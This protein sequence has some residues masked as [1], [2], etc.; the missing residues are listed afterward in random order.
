MTQSVRSSAAPV[1]VLFAL[2]AGLPAAAQSLK[3]YTV[4]N[5]NDFIKN[6]G[7]KRIIALKKGDYKL[8]AGST[9][10]ND[11]VSWLDAE[12]GS[13]K[14]LSI[15]NVEGLQII[16]ETGTRFV[17]ESES[18]YMLGFYNGSQISLSNVTLERRLK[19]ESAYVGAGMIYAEGVSGFK[20]DKLVFKGPTGYSLEF[21]DCEEIELKRLEITKG[22]SG[23]LVLGQCYD[24]SLADSKVS[25]TE[26]YPLVYLDGSDFVTFKNVTFEGNIGG[27]FV[28]IYA[29]EG[30][31]EEVAF[32]GCTFKDN[33][34]EWFSG[35]QVLPTTSG[36]AF[37]GSSFDEDWPELS[38]APEEAYYDE[39][40]AYFYHFDSGLGFYYPEYW[41]LEE[42]EDGGRALIS[43]ADEDVLVLF[44]KVYDIPAKVDPARQSKRVFLEAQNALVRYLSDELGLALELSATGEAYTNDWGLLVADY[45]GE[46]DGYLIRVRFVAEGGAVYALFVAAGSADYFEDGGDGLFI[47]DSLEIGG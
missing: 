9:V 27:N 39:G 4:S 37:V 10:K 1:L 44:D 6:I 13:G 43:S 30:Y 24:V 35:T 5:L 8:S 33:D 45:E 11:Y 23:A 34:F 18:A 22:S 15:S 31:V 17:S 20:A 32:E 41:Q 19:D 38:V 40:P 29:E 21:W 46:A 47:L 28:E 36:C 42:G 26:G 25:G 16:G 14:E 3:T 7:P 12:D 2:L